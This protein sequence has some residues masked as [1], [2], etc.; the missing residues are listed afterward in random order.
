MESLCAFCLG[1]AM[2]VSALTCAKP[3]IR[4]QA[5]SPCYLFPLRFLRGATQER[6][7]IQIIRARRVLLVNHFVDN[8][9]LRF[10]LHDVLLLDGLFIAPSVPRLR[11]VG[12]LLMRLSA[13]RLTES[14]RNNGNLHLLFHG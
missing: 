10:F 4:T 8:G 5:E 6:R 9:T 11:H 12:G 13:R 14:R 3:N 1:F 2:S 7:H